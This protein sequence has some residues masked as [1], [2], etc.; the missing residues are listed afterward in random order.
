M[1]RKPCTKNDLYSL[2]RKLRKG[3]IVEVAYRTGYSAGHVSNVLNGRRND[4]DC[5]IYDTV[6]SIVKGR[7]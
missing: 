3:E 7:R 2:A 4:K 5:Y 1:K 6:K